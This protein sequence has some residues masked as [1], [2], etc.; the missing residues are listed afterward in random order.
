MKPAKLRRGDEVRVISP[1]N[2]LAVV[3]ESLEKRAIQRLEKL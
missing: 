1:S 3:S 2:S